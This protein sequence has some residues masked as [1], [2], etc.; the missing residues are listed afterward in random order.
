LRRIAFRVAI[1][2]ALL[3]ILLG[4]AWFVASSMGRDFLRHELERQLS[5][6]M[7]GEVRIPEIR[8]ELHSGLAVRGYDV[9]VYPAS[10]GPGLFGREVYAELSETAALLGSFQLAVL[11]IEDL[12][13]RLQRDPS[14][15][16]QFPPLRALQGL[17]GATQDEDPGSRLLLITALD[18]VTRALMRDRSIADLVSIQR[19][20]VRFED[21]ETAHHEP[22]GAQPEP[23]AKTTQPLSVALEDLRA[24]LSRPWHSGQS[25]LRLIATLIDP[26]SRQI[27][28]RLPASQR[29]VSGSRRSTGSRRWRSSHTTR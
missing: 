11:S 9:S 6:L 27:S 29:F 3:T 7:N 23:T 20:I 17:P 25:E 16:W 14:G 1:A 18:A 26:K 5:D 4:A 8:F 28:A 12:E 22:S 24:D 10:A 15:M 21:L 13:V 2:C 19:G